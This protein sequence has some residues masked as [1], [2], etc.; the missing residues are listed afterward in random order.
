MLAISIPDIAKNTAT[1]RI[2]KCSSKGQV[3][4]LEKFAWKSITASAATP[5]RPCTAKFRDATGAA[6][7]AARTSTIANVIPPTPNAY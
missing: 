2:P 7:N 6:T 1:P 5:L 3:L 4:V